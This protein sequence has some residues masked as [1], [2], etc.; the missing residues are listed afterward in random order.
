MAAHTGQGINFAQDYNCYNDNTECIRQ[1]TELK[2]LGITKIRVNII[3]Y[4]AQDFNH[5]FRDQLRLVCTTALSMGFYVIW[6]YKSDTLLTSGNQAAFKQACRDGATWAQSVGLS[7]WTCGNEE[8]LTSSLSASALRA[9]LQDTCQTIK[10]TDGFSGVVSTAI[11]TNVYAAWA[12][13]VGTWSVYMKLNL[14]IYFAV[15][16]TGGASFDVYATTVPAALGAGN[17]YCGEYGVNGAQGN[18][19]LSTAFKTDDQWVSEMYRRTKLLADNGWQ[20][21]YYFAYSVQGD[22]NEELRWSAYRVTPAMP[23]PLLRRLGR[24]AANVISFPLT[25]TTSKLRYV[26]DAIRVRQNFASSLVFNGSSGVVSIGTESPFTGIFY[27]SQWIKWGGINGNFHTI[28]AKRDSYDVAAL[29]FSMSINTSGVLTMDTIT[30]FVT[31]NY[32]F[33]LNRWAHMV[34][35]HDTSTN[36]DNLYINGILVSSQGIATFGSKTT[37]AMTIGSTQSG[38]YF[39]GKMGH[40]VIGNMTATPTSDEL[41]YMYARGVYPGT[42]FRSFKFNEGSGIIAIDSSTNAV[43]ATISGATYST[44]VP[45]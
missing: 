36:T 18:G 5:P 1:L 38:D 29:M 9:A 25:S 22:A 30:S 20:S 8:D 26:K 43:N 39:N 41:W 15:G 19:R 40:A 14:H 37:A 24:V 27:C 6:G 16:A 45:I 17:V 7:E 34:W 28:F 42:S 23:T 31:W 44:D 10:V 11:T 13:E 35:V 32:T 33:P 2:A 3:S 4:Q 12:A 21:F